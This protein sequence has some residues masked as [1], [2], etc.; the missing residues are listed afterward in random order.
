MDNVSISVAGFLAGYVGR[1]RLQ[2]IV[3]H[4]EAKWG[5]VRGCRHAGRS[6]LIVKLL[7]VHESLIALV[8]IV[9]SLSQHTVQNAVST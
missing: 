1:G 7:Y 4:A 8:Q 6:L 5:N 2:D 9:T 3:T